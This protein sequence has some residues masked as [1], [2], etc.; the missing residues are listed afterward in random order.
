MKDNNLKILLFSGNTDAVVSY[1]ETEEYIRQIGWKQT[2]DK[3][4]FVNKRES[5]LGW[6]T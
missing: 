3:T 1:I 6:K 4:P 5:L 2:G